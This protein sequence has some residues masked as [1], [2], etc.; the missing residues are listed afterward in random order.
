MNVRFVLALF[1]ALIG[2]AVAVPVVAEIDPAP[3]RVRGEGPFDQLILRGVTLIDGT[4]APPNG[5]V[6]IVIEGDRIQRIVAVGAPGMEIDPARRPALKDGG[7]E[8]DLHGYHV[9]PGFVDMHGH[10]GGRAQGTP[11]EYVYKLWLG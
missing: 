10:I 6:D 8:V 11:A 9:L 3:D 1:L 4:G 5:P 7:R 2:L